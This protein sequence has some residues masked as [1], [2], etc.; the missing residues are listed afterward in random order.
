[1]QAFKKVE[2]LTHVGVHDAAAATYKNK[3]KNQ[4]G[5]HFKY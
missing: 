3:I 5:I 4:I 2:C 1:M